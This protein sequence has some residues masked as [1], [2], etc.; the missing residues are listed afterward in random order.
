MG[1]DGDLPYNIFQNLVHCNKLENFSCANCTVEWH[2]QDGNNVPPIEPLPGQF[3]SQWLIRRMPLSLQY[4]NGPVYEH[5][6]ERVLMRYN[7]ANVLNVCPPFQLVP[8]HI[9]YIDYYNEFADEEDIVR[10]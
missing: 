9:N 10:V 4:F 5:D 3:C 2:D 6:V 1:E 7:L 8:N